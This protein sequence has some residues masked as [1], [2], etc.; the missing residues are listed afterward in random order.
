MKTQHVGTFAFT[1][2]L[3]KIAQYTGRI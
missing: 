2:D 1:G 3:P